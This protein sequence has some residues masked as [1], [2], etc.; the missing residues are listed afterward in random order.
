MNR[1]LQQEFDILYKIIK[2]KKWA[3]SR[4]EHE[5]F[6]KPVIPP[7]LVQIISIHLEPINSQTRQCF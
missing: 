5:P 1:D 2:K 3:D 7:V 6:K 4:I